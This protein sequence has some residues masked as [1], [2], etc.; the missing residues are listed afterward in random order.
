MRNLEKEN[1]GVRTD[2]E[3]IDLENLL[4]YY[5]SYLKSNRMRGLYLFWMEFEK[6]EWWLKIK[7]FYWK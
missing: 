1:I 7:E 6:Q 3:I 4:I 2:W 5:A